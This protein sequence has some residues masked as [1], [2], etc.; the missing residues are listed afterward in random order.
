MASAS[1][2]LTALGEA[3]PGVLPGL[4][5]EPVAFWAAP[6]ITASG[7]WRAYLDSAAAPL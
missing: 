2:D 4:W 6:D 7:G 5:C 3:D 1:P